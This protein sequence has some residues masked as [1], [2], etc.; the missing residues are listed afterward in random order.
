MQMKPGARADAPWTKQRLVRGTQHA[1]R[2]IIA[3][4][5]TCPHPAQQCVLSPE[6]EHTN[7]T[8]SWR[9]GQSFRP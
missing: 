4:V 1:T 6:S 5:L 2:S 7:G 8:G 9:A 3:P